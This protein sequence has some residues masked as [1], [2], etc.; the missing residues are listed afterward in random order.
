MSD[1]E[2]VTRKAFP[3]RNVRVKLDEDV[4]SE[5]NSYTDIHRV[6]RNAP[7]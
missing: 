4:A 1:T 2:L 5:E 6:S 7:H 3:T